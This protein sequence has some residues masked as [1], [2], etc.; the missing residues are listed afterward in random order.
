M[1][2]APLGKLSEYTGW[3]DIAAFGL[4]RSGETTVVLLEPVRTEARNA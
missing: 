3:G 4:V 1:S 2:A